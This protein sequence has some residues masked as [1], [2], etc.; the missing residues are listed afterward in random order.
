MSELKVGDRVA[1]VG[2]FRGIDDTGRAKV[3]TAYKT[4]KTVSGKSLIKL[5]PKRRRIYT[6]LKADQHSSM[7][8]INEFQAIERS[9]NTVRWMGEP[10]PEVFEFVEVRKKK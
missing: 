8:Y 9:A 7:A 5:K 3:E 1:L 6:T 10:T 2:I 4:W